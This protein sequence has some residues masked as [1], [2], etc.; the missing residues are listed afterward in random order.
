MHS[1]RRHFVLLCGGAAMAE[2]L[3]PIRNCWV[4]G[5]VNLATPSRNIKEHIF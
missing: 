5:K 4:A 3:T 2:P 1:E